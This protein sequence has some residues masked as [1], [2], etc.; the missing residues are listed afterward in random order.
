MSSLLVSDFG[1]DDYSADLST[2]GTVSVGGSVS[3]MIETGDDRD[4]FRIELAAGGIYAFDLK[5]AGSGGGTLSD[6][7]LLLLDGSGSSLVSDDDSGIGFDSRLV[8]SAPSG[9]VFYLSVDDVANVGGSYTLMA[10]ELGFDDYAG[11]SGTTGTITVGGTVNG[12]IQFNGDQDWFR[13]E[14]TAGRIYAFD[15]KGVDSA[16]G[17]LPYAYLQLLTDASAYAAADI[18]GGTGND[19]RLILSP[20]SNS[21]YFLTAQSF[22]GYLGT[23]TLVATEIGTD[24]YLGNTNTTAMLTMDGAVSGNVQF[25]GDQDWFRIDLI[26]GQI[27]AFDQ[28]GAASGSGSLPD[29]ILRLLNAAGT[30]VTATYYSGTSADAHLVYSPLSGGT[31]YLSAQANYNSTGS[32]TLAATNLGTDDYLVSTATTGTLTVGG[33][34]TGNIQFS[35]DIDW[36]RVDLTAGRIYSIDLK[37]ADSAAGTLLDP[38]LQLLDGSASYLAYDNDSGTGSDSRLIYSPLISGDFYLSAHSASGTLGTYRVAVADIGADDCIGSTATSGNLT[39]GDSITGNIQFAGDNDW[40]RIALTAGQI[41]AFEL[42]GIDS[43]GGTLADPFLLLLDS[44][45][46]FLGSNLGD[47][48]GSDA[49]LRL[50]LA[51]SGTYYL[52]AQGSS[53]T[54]TISATELGTDDYAG[55]ATTTGMLSMGGSITGNIQFN[56]DQDWFRVDLVAGHFYVFDMKGV[57]S[58][59]GSLPNPGLQINDG[60]GYLATDFDSGIGTD[61]RLDFVAVNS[62]PYY[63][64]TFGSGGAGTYTLAATDLGADDYDSSIATTGSLV[65]G[66]SI[67][68]NIQLAIDFDW[69]RIELSA[70][71]IYTFDLKGADSGGGTLVDPNLQLRDSA[72]SLLFNDYDSGTGL[73]ARLTYLAASSGTYY[74]AATAMYENRVGS[75]TLT[76]TDIGADDHVGNVTTTSILVPGGSATGDIQFTNDQDWFRIDLSAGT[77]YIFTLRGAESG[78]GTLANPML[79][80]L[81]ASGLYLDSGYAN[82][83]DSGLL[84]AYTPTSSGTFYLSAQTNYGSPGGSYTLSVGLDDYSGS[85]LTSGTIAAGGTATG[86]T[87][88]AG[89]QDWFRINLSAGTEYVFDLTASGVAD[90]LNTY[91]VLLDS[92]GNYLTNDESHLFLTPDTNAMYYLA[93]QGYNPGSSF[94]LTA[95]LDDYANST[96]TTGILTPG[97][98]LTGVLQD[99]SDKDWIK[100]TL[101]AGSS[102]V[103]SLEG[104]DS[105]GGTLIDPLLRLRDSTGNEITHNLDGGIG[106]DAYL[107]YLAPSSGTYYLSVESQYGYGGDGDTYTLSARNLGS[108]YQATPASNVIPLTGTATLDGLIQ[109]SAWQFSGAKVLTYSFNEVTDEGANLGGPWTETQKD[110]VR[111]ALLAWEAV[112]NIS[113]FEIPGSATIENNTANIAFGHVGDF[114]YPAAGLGIFP[115]PD[116]ANQFLVEAEYSRA[117]YPRLEGD[118]LLDD[119]AG[120]MQ[121]LSPGQSGFWV[122]L[123]ELGHTLGL[124]HPFDDGANGRPTFTDLGIGAMDVSIQTTMSY[125][126]PEYSLSDGYTATPMLLDIQAIQRMYGANTTYHNTDNTYTLADDGALRTLWDT[127]GNDWLDASNLGTGL[128]LNL[129]AGSI[130]RFGWGNSV[131][132]IAHGVSIENARGSFAADTLYGTSAANILDGGDGNDTLDGRVGEDTL[133]GGLGNDTYWVDNRG[134]SVRETSALA[135]EIDS[136]QATLSWTLATNLENLTLLGDKKFSANGNGLDNT[137]TGNAAANLLDGGT[138]ADTLNGGT[139]NDVYVVDHAND[140]IQETQTSSTEIDSVRAF[141]DWTLGANLENLTL[142]GTKNLDGSGNSLNNTLTGNGGNN[143]FSGGNGNDF[144]D[145]A[146]GNDTLTGDAGTDT[147]AFTTPLNVLRNVDTIADFS[148]G[149]DKLLLS[150]AIFR[151]LGFSGTPSTDVFFHSGSAAHDANDRILYDTDTGALFYDADGSGVLAAVQLAALSSAPTLLYT[152]FVVG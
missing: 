96:A 51:N 107:S 49:Y 68:G 48:V 81:S 145:G 125:D 18:G 121:Y 112:A 116:F 110:A 74:L 58:G 33:A 80:L 103:F 27:Y 56:S 4:W 19:A 21:A 22:D 57:D 104:R 61:A 75:Y 11:N 76:A 78:I 83:A 62:G 23:Y 148:S 41:Y 17:T 45:G 26:A 120:E 67:T 8:F 117:E 91:L 69:F 1:V 54:Y 71:R 137:L 99:G 85:T 32:Y 134:D 52:A 106:A 147:F 63:L 84:L 105:G 65:P 9:G 29:P 151:E 90:G 142:L 135:G 55:N 119:Y 13:I 115:S 149:M 100:I 97:G 37:G 140:T 73:D 38:Y 144:L 114:L 109:G 129:A 12:N 53:G 28:K 138:G 82:G 128:Q 50:S 72:G 70:G 131:T 40:F 127:G 59:G 6:P 133:I 39:V 118:V 25:N 130:N 44:A 111:E 139:G 88:F 47:G 2:T 87:Q 136:V 123:H 102:Y 36:F 124:K 24:D 101:S 150:S 141:V 7:V 113:F 60:T 108:G 79:Q 143:T 15:M 152:D 86:V 42:R 30:E 146:S 34:V 20:G 89:D 35:T 14:L 43:A 122:G 5:G 31:Y 94:I 98:T 46:N 16:S 10:T 64:A 93:A 95:G 66:G 126:T 77:T 92:A 3:G 132:A